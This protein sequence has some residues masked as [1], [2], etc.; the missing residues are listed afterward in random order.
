LVNQDKNI[1]FWTTNMLDKIQN[2]NPKSLTDLSQM[3]DLMIVFMNIVES[4][5]KSKM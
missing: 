4:Q 5:A 1:I 2:I 3:Q